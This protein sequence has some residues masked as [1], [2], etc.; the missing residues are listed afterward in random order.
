MGE[1]REEQDSV[2]SDQM[3]N[4]ISLQVISM[5]NSA[6]SGHRDAFQIGFS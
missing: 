1:V 3:T 2:L 6:Q 5:L 4:S